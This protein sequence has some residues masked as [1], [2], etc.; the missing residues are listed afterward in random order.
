MSLEGIDDI[1]G[2]DSLSLGVLGVGNGVLDNVLEEA[3]EDNSGLVI[4]EGADSLDTTSSGESSDG[5]L[6]DTHDGGLDGLGGVSL[7]T[8]LSGDL[9]ELSTL[10][11][12][13]THLNVDLKIYNSQPLPDYKVAANPNSA[14]SLASFDFLKN[15][16]KSRLLTLSLQFC[17]SSLS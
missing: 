6:G 17:P 11:F 2:S 10:G 7:G 8:G 14:I 12:S 1:K 3:S 5:G 9:S 13:G 16:L 15:P 4:D